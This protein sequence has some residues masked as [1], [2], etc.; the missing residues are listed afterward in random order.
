MN[1][2]VIDRIDGLSSAAAIKGPCR[3][4]TTANILLTGL[5]T[6]DG[7]LLASGDR[8]LVKD[9][10]AGSEN[11][12]WIADT[13]P[14]RRSKDFSRTKDVVQGTQVIVADGTVGAGLSWSVATPNPVDV[15]GGSIEFESTGASGG[16]KTTVGPR[17]GSF[18][19]RLADRDIQYITPRDL[20][21][22]GSGTADDNLRIL[23]AIDVAVEMG[24]NR[25]MFDGKFKS[26]IPIEVNVPMEF[27]GRGWEDQ[28]LIETD[29]T[30]AGLL[31]AD[32]DGLD[33]YNFDLS[34]YSANDI[35]NGSGLYGTCL[36][37]GRWFPGD[38]TMQETK[39]VRADTM[40]F[41]RQEGGTGHATAFTGR[42][43]GGFIINSLIR[44]A[45][46]STPH[47]DGHLGHWSGESEGVSTTSIFY[48]NQTIAFAFGQTIIGGT[49]G[50]RARIVK[51]IDLGG[52]TG[53]LAIKDVVGVFADN[54][55]IAAV[56]GG[57]AQANGQTWVWQLA[58][59][60]LT[61]T[62]SVG[63]TI[64]G[65]GGTPPT[66]K[67]TKIDVLSG[68]TGI[69]YLTDQASVGSFTDNMAFT[70]ATGGADCDGARANTGL[71]QAPF[72]PGRYSYHPNGLWLENNTYEFTQR[73]AAWSACYDM[74]GKNLKANDP[75][76]VQLLDFPIGDEGETFAHPEDFGHVYSGYDFDGMY[77]KLSQGSGSNG[78]TVIDGS[79]FN[80]SKQLDSDLAAYA[81]PDY[82]GM[83]Y[84]GVQ[85]RFRQFYWYANSLRNFVF[86][87]GPRDPA[88]ST[89]Y[90]RMIFF[91][92]MIGDWQIHNFRGK[93]FDS[94]SDPG[95]VPLSL[96]IDNFR[97]LM[98]IKGCNFN[99]GMFLRSFDGVT[100]DGCKVN[101]PED[102]PTS[103][104]PC[105]DVEG[106][107][108]TLNTDATGFVSG[109]TSITLNAATTLRIPVGTPLYYGTSCVFVAEWVE[110]GD[111][112]I[113]TTEIP[114]TDSGVTPFVVDQ[115]FSNFNLKN[116]KVNAGRRGI[117]LTGPGTLNTEGG[118]IRSATQYGILIGEDSVVH[119]KGTD[120]RNN[121]NSGAASYNIVINEGGTLHG[122]HL[123]L[124]ASGNINY[125]I[126]GLGEIRGGSIKNSIFEDTAIDDYMLLDVG[127]PFLWD[128][129][130]TDDGVKIDLDGVR[131]PAFQTLPKLYI[132]G[133]SRGDQSSDVGR[134][135]S[136]G[137]L[138]H[139]QMLTGAR[140]DFQPSQNFAVGGDN[141]EQLLA[142]VNNLL[143]VDPGIVCVIC[144]T[145]DRTGGWT[146]E[147]TITALA[148]WQRLVLGHGH[149]I[150]WLAETPRGD[151]SDGTY[152]LSTTN[153]QRH[154]RVR[155]WQY[156]Q[157]AL[158]NVF[159]ADAWPTLGDVN[160]TTA[161]ANTGLMYDGLHFG[162][163]GARLQ[164][165][166]IVPII[167][168]L[169][170]VRPR[171]VE[172]LANL[173]AANNPTGSLN[174]NP[175][176]AGT[177]G[178][179]G[180]NSSGTVAT[181]WTVTGGAGLTAVCS[182]V[183]IDAVN[184]Q[185]IVVTGTPTAAASGTTPISPDL[186]SVVASIPV[187]FAN[188]SV[189]D[190]LEVAGDLRLAAGATGCRGISIYLSLTGASGTVTY[191][192]CEIQ[193]TNSVPNLDLPSTAISGISMVPRA[194]VTE[195]LTGA[196]LK[197]I[198]SGRPGN[199]SPIS[200]T[201]D[202]S[203]VAVRKV[204]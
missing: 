186:Y 180:A 200:A 189:G 78:V 191:A 83:R 137:W 111:T 1:S 96:T 84:Q 184:Y 117:V 142:R 74:K 21:A 95:G 85:K 128:N 66:G 175:V 141:S 99:G 87:A 37:A 10:T 59:D 48:D 90:V 13:G 53:R 155:D 145:N 204:L 127:E 132:D 195:A 185:R 177:G 58:Y 187:D 15:G 51:V 165:D 203:K 131:R 171:L 124:G 5:Q 9:Q 129:N 174:A 18:S 52:G 160:A 140:F 115:S 158:A 57:S 89:D 81:G 33:L 44:G 92:N 29:N 167:T 82:N 150:I 162:P 79:G 114:V 136:R 67:I 154:L 194:T 91:R 118:S 62:L 19:R 100:I 109:A 183:T 98:D 20:G 173:W 201:L 106:V 149:R 28:L 40:L 169:L 134:T 112:E 123:R 8:V 130:Y 56:S 110:T 152:T 88:S 38:V 139:L 36:S 178:T 172:T 113:A 146:S 170:P 46:D 179:N 39:N 32:A 65:T 159:V 148:E 34:V 41:S 105:I 35:I 50:A 135:A 80:T 182:K 23:D 47:G 168:N 138:W 93:G 6:I 202:F 161:L 43:R 107:N 12:I 4:A 22:T 69:L 24:I 190:V 60:N 64:T 133:D 73:I 144:S 120:F 121:G 71:V 143:N 49:S 166:A 76:V 147:Q 151:A 199:V 75:R 54:E 125:H 3:V 45:S 188:I 122:D 164:A 63:Q 94:P 27:F 198:I 70:S 97:G 86:E 102:D 104:E 61:G 55:I 2:I 126:R 16:I 101:Q 14:W 17:T 196:S 156:R 25:V 192:S 108:T 11:G 119:M 72:P 176:L 181:S 68:T 31:F 157:A 163:P 116:T 26:T 153:R 193:E 103:G 42:Y 30:A 7:E 197:V 77:C